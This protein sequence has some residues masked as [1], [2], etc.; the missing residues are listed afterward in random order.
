MIFPETLPALIT[1]GFGLPV[2][3]C[4]TVSF[5]INS[6]RFKDLVLSIKSSEGP[7]GRLVFRFK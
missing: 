6:N 7:F 5:I 1:H 4:Y 3:S 2:N